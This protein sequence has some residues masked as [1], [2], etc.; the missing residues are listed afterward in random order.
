M[1][2]MPRIPQPKGFR[3]E[4]VEAHQLRQQLAAEIRETIMV[5]IKST[6]VPAWQDMF[7]RFADCIEP[8]SVRDNARIPYP[9]T[10][11]SDRHGTQIGCVYARLGW[12]L[13]L[14]WDT[15]FDGVNKS[16]E[17]H[18]HLSELRSWA[19]CKIERCKV[20]GSPRDGYWLEVA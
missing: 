9:V 8:G 11:P 1:L 14:Y 3:F 16:P 2:Q 15:C 13:K 17:I 19:A 20:A 6:Y 5:L 12:V 10:S 7:R 4:N 18:A